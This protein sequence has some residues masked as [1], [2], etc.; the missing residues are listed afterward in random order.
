M[1]VLVKTATHSHGWNAAR[2]AL[3]AAAI[4]GMPV[5]HQCYVVTSLRARSSSKAVEAIPCKL[6]PPEPLD[7]LIQTS[8]LAAFRILRLIV[9]ICPLHESIHNSRYMQPGPGPRLWFRLTVDSLAKPDRCTSLVAE[10][11]LYL[12]AR[13]LACGS[14]NTGIHL[15]GNFVMLFVSCS[16]RLV[17]SPA[18]AHVLCMNGEQRLTP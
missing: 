18:V 17:M 5:K 8:Y 7:Y 16:G 6:Q 12:A 2:N 10:L 15:P 9:P 14:R 11:E 3:Q 4:F 1:A 13:L